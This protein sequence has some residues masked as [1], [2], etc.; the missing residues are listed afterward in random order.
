LTS[1]LKMFLL[2]GLVFMCGMEEGLFPHFL[3]SNL[4]YHLF[5]SA[6]KE[7]TTLYFFD[8]SKAKRSGMGT[9]V[10]KLEPLLY[11]FLLNSVGICQKPPVKCR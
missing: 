11:N 7:K 10:S 9:V 2:A 3:S 5:A 8:L 4:M 1:K 6:S